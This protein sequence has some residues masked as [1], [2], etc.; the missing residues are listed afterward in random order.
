VGARVAL[1][2]KGKEEERERS[3][4]RPREGEGEAQGGCRRQ[5]NE[6]PTP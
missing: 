6:P 1:V 2:R 5:E 4:G 3:R